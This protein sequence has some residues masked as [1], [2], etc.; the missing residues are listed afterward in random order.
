ME[1]I[2]KKYE[3]RSCGKKSALL[4]VIKDNRSIASDF[5]AERIEHL[6][7]IEPMKIYSYEVIRDEADIVLYKRP[8]ECTCEGCGSLDIEYLPDQKFDN[9]LNFYPAA[10][11]EKWL[12]GF[13]GLGKR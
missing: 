2:K 5:L 12:R 4:N 8:Y 10:E 1:L 11:P 9:L 6:G 7:T 13:N 3:C